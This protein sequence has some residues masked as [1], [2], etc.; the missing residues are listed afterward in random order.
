M[1]AL[2]RNS[3]RKEFQFVTEY[4]HIYY[5]EHVTSGYVDLPVLSLIGH[6]SFSPKDTSK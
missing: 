4:L 1:V 6:I 2:S 3:G 5:E